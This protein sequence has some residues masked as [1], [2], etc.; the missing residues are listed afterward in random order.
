MERYENTIVA[1]FYGHSHA[2]EFEV[3]YDLEE[4]SIMFIIFQII[5][6]LKM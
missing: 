5:S 1:Q 2:D 4:N 6:E 3:F